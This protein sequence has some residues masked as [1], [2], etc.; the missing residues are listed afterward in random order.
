MAERALFIGGPGTLS[1][2]AI[3]ALLARSYQLAVYSHP[4]HF[5]E[6]P[7]HIRTYPGDRHDARGLSAAMQEF[8]PDVVLDFV[9]Y[10]PQEAEQTLSLVHGKVR[11]FIFVSTVDVY[12]Y[13]LSHLPLREDDPWHAKTQS[14]YAADK[15]L[16]EEFFKARFHPQQFP[17]TIARPAYSFG[18]RFILNFTSRDYGVQMLRRLKAGSPVLVPGDGTTLMHVSSAENTGR[19]IAALVDAPQALGKDYTCGHPTFTTHDGYVRL[20]A[21]ALGVQPNLVHIPSDLITSFDH[22]EARTC[23]LHALTRFNVAF[24]ID[25]FL[26]DFPEFSWH[27]TIEA[28]ARQVVEWNERNGHLIPQDDEFFDDLVIASWRKCLQ[29]YP[30]VESPVDYSEWSRSKK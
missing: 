13:P 26:R 15:R 10:N 2:S 24:S 17:L 21:D 6:L 18:P 9:C 4:S 8:C 3:Q 29:Y 12:G 11:Q 1:A 23:L 28:W 25:R 19:M 27:I 20:F 16:C 30:A 5:S 7:P 22:P 14:F